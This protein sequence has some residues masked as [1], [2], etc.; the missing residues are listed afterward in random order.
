MDDRP[1][2]E[3]RAWAAG[4]FDGEGWVKAVKSR[5]TSRP[6]A[7]I[8]QS[9]ATGVPEVLLRFRNTV[10]VGRVTGP[11]VNRHGNLPLYR[12]TASSRRDVLASYERL[13]PWLG[14][15]KTVQF[16]AALGIARSAPVRVA[17]TELAWA[18]G[19]FDGEGSVYLDKH[20]SHAGYFVV[21]AR[22]TQGNQAG[23]PEVLV[24]FR[25]ALGLGRI[26]GPLKHKTARKV[27]YRWELGG[28]AAIG[29]VVEALSPWLG[30]VKLRQAR[31]A[32]AVTDAQ[33]NLPRGN[34]A[35]GSHK[36][37]CVRGH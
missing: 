16:S 20:R 29:S 21:S 34:P 30:D 17:M 35:W 5:A 22:V 12:W 33:A 2:A 10:A 8:N 18:A 13:A 11:Y 15:V 4:F 32:F 6:F 26:R 14:L 25:E 27:I 23:V 28:R 7:Q 24:R 37:H 1:S 19:F 31:E 36:S 3:E 9:S